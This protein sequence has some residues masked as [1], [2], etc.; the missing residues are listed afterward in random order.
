M[1]LCLQKKIIVFYSILINFNLILGLSWSGGN[2]WILHNNSATPC[3]LHLRRQYIRTGKQM[4]WLGK[5][6][7]LPSMNFL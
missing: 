2:G 4:L 5:F 3:H 1:T 7:E 6:G